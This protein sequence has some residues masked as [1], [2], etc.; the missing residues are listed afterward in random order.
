MEIVGFVLNREKLEPPIV[1]MSHAILFEMIRKGGRRDK[2]T[3]SSK[4]QNTTFATKD[5]NKLQGITL[6]LLVF[7]CVQK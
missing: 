7:V 4:M 5:I 6:K 1:Q 2:I 3:G